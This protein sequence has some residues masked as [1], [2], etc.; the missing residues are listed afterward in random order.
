MKTCPFC[1]EEIQPDAIKC[2]HCSSSLLSAQPA[3]ADSPGSPSVGPNQVVYILDRDL[4]RFAKFAL[5]VLAL[6]IAVGAVLWGF[7]VKQADR[8][9]HEAEDRV[10][11]AE[12]DV[13]KT[14]AD[15]E[16]AR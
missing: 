5:G 15:V 11:H 4:V 6:F 10:R 14:K 13:N 2:K 8:S 3:G 1:R 16:G 12:D 7:D 9:A